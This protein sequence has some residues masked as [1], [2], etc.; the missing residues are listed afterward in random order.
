MRPN[1][2]LKAGRG[3]GSE[4]QRTDRKGTKEADS[5][6]LLADRVGGG[7]GEVGVLDNSLGSGLSVVSQTAGDLWKWE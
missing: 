7:G 3:R 6:E 5:T 2:G 1:E 4:G